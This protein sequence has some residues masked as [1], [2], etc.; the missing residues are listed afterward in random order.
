[1]TE[2]SRK[3]LSDILRAIG[4]IDEFQEGIL[5]YNHYRSDSKTQSAIERQLGIIGDALRKYRS[6]STKAI[7]EHDQQIISFRNR[8]IHAYDD[9]DNL[10]VWVVIQ[11]YVPEL[12]KAV[13]EIMTS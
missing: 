1:M 6:I 7:S 3:F 9:I 13:Q 5:D 4:K 11:K 12:K 10:I 2:E 8:L